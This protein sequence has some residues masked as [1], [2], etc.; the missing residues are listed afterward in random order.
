MIQKIVAK[1][2]IWQI[3]WN[4]WFKK[5]SLNSRWNIY[6]WLEFSPQGDTRIFSLML[7]IYSS[8]IRVKTD[9]Y[10]FLNWLTRCIGVLRLNRSWQEKFDSFFNCCLRSNLVYYIQRR[11]GNTVSYC[12][13]FLFQW[14]KRTVDSRRITDKSNWS[15]SSFFIVIH[16]VT[17]E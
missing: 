2:T 12:A 4:A 17:L 9:N 3:S 6:K 1:Y 7:L 16:L 15:I 5:D 11:H 10:I 13:E 8:S 14:G